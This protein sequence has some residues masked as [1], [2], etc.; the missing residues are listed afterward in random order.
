MIFDNIKNLTEYKTI[1]NLN[2]IIDFIHNKNLLELAEGEIEIKGKELFV[3]VLR[4]FPKRA[5]ENNFEIHRIYTDVQF[6]V[7]GIEKMQIT[8][9][10]NLREKT[11]YK[12]DE[13]FQFFSVF[14]YISDIVVKK[15]EFIIF[16]PNEAHRPGCYYQNIDEPILKLVFKTKI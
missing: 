14:D 2:L 10:E 4:Y 3:K 15:N 11:E 9:K 1:P 8:S 5:E 13:D 7:K 6:I 12:K 16:F